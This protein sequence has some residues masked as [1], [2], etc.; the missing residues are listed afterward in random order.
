MAKEA[1]GKAEGYCLWEIEEGEFTIGIMGTGPGFM[2]ILDIIANEQYKEYLPGLRLIGVSDLGNHPGKVRYIREQGMP[3]YRSYRDMLKAH[4]KLDLLVELVGKRFSLKKIRNSIPETLSLIDHKSAIFLC[5]LHS[6]LQVSSH[7][8]S[9]LDRQKALLQTIIDE[10]RED[11]L[12]LDKEGRVV[13]T[14]KN[15]TKRTGKE[16]SELLGMPCW[17]VQTLP[18]GLPFCNKMDSRC[19]F[20]STLARQKAAEALV[21]RVATDGRL[22]Y[23]RIYSYPIFNSNGT[24][25][26]ILVMRRDI[27]ERTHQEKHQQHTEKLSVIGEMSTYLAHEIRNPLFAIGG[28][29]NSLLKS[30]NLT[31]RELEKLQIIADETKRLDKMLTSIL[32]FSRPSKTTDATVD[33]NKVMTE[34]VDLMKMGYGKRGIRFLIYTYP[35]LPLVNGEPEMVKQCLV[36]LIKNSIEAMPDGGDISLT[37]GADQNFIT[38][39]VSDTGTGMDEKELANAFS[40]FYST[41]EQG[42]GLGLAMINK[43]VDEYG[44]R[45]DLTSKVGEGTT[46]TLCFPPVCAVDCEAE[47]ARDIRSV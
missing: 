19:P 42:C 7:C 11:I 43:I 21:T 18:D 32:N 28:F 46:V 13:D 20:H 39:A 40:P 31:E 6:M 23:F 45:V 3:I 4:P 9:H 5:G 33:L 16:K 17:R 1:D 30:K 2:S 15:V 35:K 12:L 47:T 41:K 34:T 10:V 22:Q 24:M 36:N 27:T 25:T 38:I 29:T 37:T 8:Q 14:N 26:H 44:G